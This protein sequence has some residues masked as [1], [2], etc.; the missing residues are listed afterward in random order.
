MEYHLAEANS[1]EKLTHA[2]NALIADGWLP[3]GGV[4]VATYGAGNWWYYQAMVRR[5]AP[6]A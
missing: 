5:T 2:V 1:A 3:S 6:T 4:A